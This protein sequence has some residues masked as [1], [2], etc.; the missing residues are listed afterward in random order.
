MNYL[1]Y[2]QKLRISLAEK[3]GYII[4][5]I[6]VFFLIKLGF[7][8]KFHEFF[9]DESVYIG[10]G[11]Y[12]F[13]LGNIGIWEPMRPIILP[14]ILGGI[15]RLGLDLAFFG[16]LIILLFS[17]GTI[18]LTYLIAEELF[19][20]KIALISSLILAFTPVF[21]KFSILFMTGIPS[22][23][24]SMLA[25]YLYIRK[26]SL[27]M[28]GFFASI[29]FLTRFPQALI[30]IS[31]GLVIIL[32]FLRKMADGKSIINKES[33]KK[34]RK[35]IIKDN[36]NILSRQLT[37]YSSGILF[38]VVLFFIANLLMY[39]N[40][41]SGISDA[42]F[43]PLILAFTHVSNIHESVGG[44][45]Y[46]LFFYFIE[47]FLNNYLL[48]FAIAGLIIAF[49]IRKHRTRI[50]ILIVPLIAYIVF[51]TMIINKQLRFSILFLP[52]VAIFAGYAII[53][54]IKYTL[55]IKSGFIKLTLK[56]I[57]FIFLISFVI[58]SSSMILI[59]DFRI[60]QDMPEEPPDI[61]NDFYY[62]KIANYKE[63]ILTSDP[64][65]LAYIDKHMIA[66]YQ[67]NVE[68][69]EIYEEN[70]LNFGTII[71][72]N[73]VYPCLKEDRECLRRNREFQ[74]KI[75]SEN[76][77]I[78]EVEYYGIKYFIFK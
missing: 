44:T 26:K 48:A 24:F 25:I 8:F 27:F 46:N 65:S 68:G 51:F 28:V 58:F 63:P 15:W 39:K 57:I 16:G 45:I 66:Y 56:Y 41:T 13:S 42:I 77:L 18:L 49:S 38:P 59:Q 74:K 23:F 62:G 60:F 37:S 61:V 33:N 71:F 10:M 53:E 47:V 76:I 17:C 6:L 5:L 67:D 30:V 55:I 52:L 9:W 29:S 36:I 50:L 12:I 78:D 43:R 72:H 32:D 40:V 31:I 3:K 21:F 19:D 2:Y 22:A 1:K 35:S 11:K 70:K 20:R 14:V 7:L 4:F 54:I 73:E 75:E 34:E 69:L 64:T